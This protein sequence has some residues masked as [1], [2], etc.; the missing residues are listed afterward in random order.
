M[1]RD[2]LAR[3][4]AHDSEQVGV[5]AGEARLLVSTALTVADWDSARTRDIVD[6]I[7]HEAAQ[8]VLSRMNRAIQDIVHVAREKAA[9]VYPKDYKAS[10]AE[11]NEL[12]T[13]YAI[14]AR[15]VGGR[16]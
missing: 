4:G 16:G 2:R 5:P 10:T 3:V 11:L 14:T 7:T 15:D 8:H 6:P 1:I 9:I 13:G 12:F